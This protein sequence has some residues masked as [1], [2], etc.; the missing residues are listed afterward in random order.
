VKS[1]FDVTN[2]LEQVA[3]AA[4]F[5]HPQR[6]MRITLECGHYRLM[7]ACNCTGG[8]IGWST[9]CKLCEESQSKQVVRLIVNVE[10]TGVL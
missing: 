8:G 1:S 10:E 3:A 9:A 6:L 2:L 4:R 7:E 5:E